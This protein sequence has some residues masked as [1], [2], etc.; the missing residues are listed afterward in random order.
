M[1]AHYYTPDIKVHITNEAGEVLLDR[2]YKEPGNHF[3]LPD[4]PIITHNR[5]RLMGKEPVDFSYVEALFEIYPPERVHDFDDIKVKRS[6]T[7][8]DQACI[9]PQLQQI[10]YNPDFY[11]NLRSKAAK[12]LV[13]FHEMGH[14]FYE[15]ETL[16]DLFGATVLYSYGYPP[17]SIIKASKESLGMKPQNLDRLEKLLAYLQQLE[18]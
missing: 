2:I 18:R 12:K 14:L 7:E 8:D 13:I 9:Y 10:Y 4:V 11:N 1:V 15:D 16:A 3:T 6:F 5:V 17:Y